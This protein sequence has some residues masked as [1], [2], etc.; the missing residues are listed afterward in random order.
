MLNALED[1]LLF[2]KKRKN[3]LFITTVYFRIRFVF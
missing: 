2:P 3:T 1:G